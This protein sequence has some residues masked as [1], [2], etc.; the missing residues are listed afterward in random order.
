MPVVFDFTSPE[1]MTNGFDGLITAV[2]LLI[3]TA[4]AYNMTINFGREA[5][6]GKKDIPWVIVMTVPVIMVL[7][8]GV[9]IINAG[10]YL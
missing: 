6:D 8:V 2:F 5:K 7:Y 1:F 3:F 4:T 10:V 9:A